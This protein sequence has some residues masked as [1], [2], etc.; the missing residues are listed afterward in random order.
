M[1]NPDSVNRVNPPNTTIP[2]TEP[3]L[4]SSQYATDLE[5]VS[6]NIVVLG[7]EATSLLGLGVL[8]L[9][10]R[11]RMPRGVCV[12]VLAAVLLSRTFLGLK[13][14][15]NFGS[16]DFVVQRWH[17]K[18]SLDNLGPALRIPGKSD[19]I[20]ARRLGITV[21]RVGDGKSNHRQLFREGR[22]I[23]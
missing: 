13:S 21:L 4:A 9:I 17:R 20:P 16:K 23:T 19:A 5:L 18:K 11:L 12:F 8:V 7:R 14:L 22:P 1:T 10:V 15:E 2:K 3:A 6:G